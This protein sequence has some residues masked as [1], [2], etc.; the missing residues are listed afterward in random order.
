MGCPLV[1]AR[2]AVSFP[3]GEVAAS[4]NAAAAIRKLRD[5]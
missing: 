1:A 4:A 3:D 2:A 5:N